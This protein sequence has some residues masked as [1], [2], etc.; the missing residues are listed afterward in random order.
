MLIN[1]VFEKHLEVVLLLLW[2]RSIEYVMYMLILQMQ[3]IYDFIQAISA[4]TLINE[5][6]QHV[7]DTDIKR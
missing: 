5:P 7:T 1:Q 3:N 4:L 2:G 6:V